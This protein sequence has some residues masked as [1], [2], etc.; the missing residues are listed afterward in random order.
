MAWV[1]NVPF[2]GNW[3][4]SHEIPYRFPIRV[5]YRIKNPADAAESLLEVEGKFFFDDPNSPGSPQEFI[6]CGGR[7]FH[8]VRWKDNFCDWQDVA[9][10]A[11][12]INRQE[13]IS[14]SLMKQSVIQLILKLLL[15]AVILPISVILGLL[16]W[17][18]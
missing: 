15:L 13:S 10:Y 12:K 5:K 17:A 8:A 6:T 9:D 1:P 3:V 4:T 7:E 18:A 2:R 11:L 16:L 14:S